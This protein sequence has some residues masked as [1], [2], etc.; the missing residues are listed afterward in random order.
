MTHLCPTVHNVYSVVSDLN[1]QMCFEIAEIK[2]TNFRLGDS[3][4]S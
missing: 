1:Q 3:G 4:N 2:V